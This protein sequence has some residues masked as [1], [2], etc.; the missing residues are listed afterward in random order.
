VI[1]EIEA[2]VKPRIRT[3]KHTAAIL[4]NSEIMVRKLIRTDQLQ[5]TCIGAM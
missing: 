5:T 3:V 4:D 2:D 1:V